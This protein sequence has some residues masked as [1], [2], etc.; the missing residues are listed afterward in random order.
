MSIV[1]DSVVSVAKEIKSEEVTLEKAV[2]DIFEAEPHLYDLY[3][4][5]KE[6]GTQIEKSG[7][8]EGAIT[9]WDT[10][11]RG[12]KESVEEKYKRLRA[13]ADVKVKEPWRKTLADKIWDGYLASVYIIDE[14][15]GYP[16]HTEKPKEAMTVLQALKIV[17]FGDHEDD[18]VPS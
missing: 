15:T 7:T 1:Y 16:H 8:T 4:I 2:A 9:G 14:L 12:Q 6:Y 10:R 5:E 13:I 11:G 18:E 17:L 3:L